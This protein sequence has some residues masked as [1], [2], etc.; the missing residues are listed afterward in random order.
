MVRVETRGDRNVRR[1]RVQ[2]GRSRLIAL[3]LAPALAPA[4]VQSC[5]CGVAAGLLVQGERRAMA[6]ATA[7]AM[8]AMGAVCWGV[9]GRAVAEGTAGGGKVMRGCASGGGH[10]I[11]RLRA[12]GR[13]GFRVWD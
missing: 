5:F 7:A 3:A 13:W 11:W 4:L 6:M 2:L 10:V 9:L 8:A 1:A 12:S